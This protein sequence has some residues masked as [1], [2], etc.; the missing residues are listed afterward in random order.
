MTDRPFVR[1]AG[2]AAHPVALLGG[3]W[4]GTHLMPRS[5]EP[6]VADFSNAKPLPLISIDAPLQVTPTAFPRDGQGA[7]PIMRAPAIV[8][9]R[10]KHDDIPTESSTAAPISP[11]QAV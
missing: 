4:V 7:R 6:R 9:V 5:H 10:P 2:I 3:A 8:A 1:W 11:E